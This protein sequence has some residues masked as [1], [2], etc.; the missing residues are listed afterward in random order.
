MAHNPHVREPLNGPIEPHVKAQLCDCTADTPDT[1]VFFI[2]SSIFLFRESENG[3]LPHGRRC[4]AACPPGRR[5]YGPEAAGSFKTLEI[6]RLDHALNHLF[7][8]SPAP[9]ASPVATVERTGSQSPGE[10]MTKAKPLQTTAH[11]QDLSITNKIR[12]KSA[13][14]C[15]ESGKNL[16]N[17][18]ADIFLY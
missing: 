18:S 3:K 12:A 5:L 14:N 1:L 8:I 15:I 9:R 16:S 7:P 4:P 13:V 2:T 17:Y 10:T 11:F 6:S